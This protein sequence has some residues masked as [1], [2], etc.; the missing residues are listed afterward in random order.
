MEEE[1]YIQGNL[2]NL[3]RM[4]CLD[5]DGETPRE[6][7]E[8]VLPIDQNLIKIWLDGEKMFFDIEGDVSF[9]IL[10]REGCFNNLEILKRIMFKFSIF[11]SGNTDFDKRVFQNNILKLLTR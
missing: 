1:K 3:I 10:E 8:N 9:F 11:P 4:C 7:I 2:R 6:Q 5:I